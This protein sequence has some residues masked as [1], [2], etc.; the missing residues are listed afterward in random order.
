MTHEQLDNLRKF[1][2]QESRGSN[3]KYTTGRS[4]P[5]LQR[6]KLVLQE[7]RRLTIGYT[8]C[9]PLQKLQGLCKSATAYWPLW[10]VW[11]SATGRFS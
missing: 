1:V 10:K 5:H 11:E 2:L 7:S 4:S 9:N 3:F 6:H 8:K